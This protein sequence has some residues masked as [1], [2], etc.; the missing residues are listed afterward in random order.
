MTEQSV[1][2]KPVVM[3]IDDESDT[4]IYLIDLLQSAGYEVAACGSTFEAQEELARVRPDVIVLDLRLPGMTGQEFL[5]I[6][7]SLAPEIPVLVLTA[8]G[9]WETYQECRDKGAAD[10]M[11]KP[12][13]AGVLLRRLEEIRRR[14]RPQGGSVRK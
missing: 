5:P 6:L 7:R 9:D 8:Y 4:R 11:Y 14:G 3:V 13:G 2:R 10:L 12:F 1:E